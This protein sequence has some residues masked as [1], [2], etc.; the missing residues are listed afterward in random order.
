MTGLL[1]EAP[2]PT[3][4]ESAVVTR[5][6]VGRERIERGWCQ[7]QYWRSDRRDGE[8]TTFCALGAVGFGFAPIASTA[9]QCEH[10]L[11]VAL[12]TLDPDARAV[13]RWNDLALREKA[14]VLALYDRA[15]EMELAKV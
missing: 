7:G 15:I 4:V 13:S 8:P 5:L 1:Y 11:T 3:V 9:R 10:A 2:T 14:D 12:K 6:R